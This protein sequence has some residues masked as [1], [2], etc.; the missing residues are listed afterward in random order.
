[1][2]PINKLIDFIHENPVKTLKY[3]LIFAGFFIA[4]SNYFDCFA[5]RA[6]FV[7]WI[8]YV[9]IPGGMAIALFIP[10]HTVLCFILAMAGVLCIVDNGDPKSLSYGIIFLLFS[11]RIADDPLYTVIMLFTTALSILGQQTRFGLTPVDAVN[12]RSAN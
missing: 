6:P 4:I 5:E 12:K 1:M 9:V 8:F 7:E 3:I 2:E 10:H 11:A